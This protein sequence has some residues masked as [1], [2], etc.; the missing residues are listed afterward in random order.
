MNRASS[1]TV[2]CDV[3]GRPLLIELPLPTT[4]QT[5]EQVL[6]LA[7]RHITLHELPLDWEAA[8]VGVWGKVCP[9]NTLVR[10]GDRVACPLLNCARRTSLNYSITTSG[11]PNSTGWPLSMKT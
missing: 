9:R 4:G 11:S 6:A 3:A 2:V 8:P 10:N 5:L 1:C 7:R